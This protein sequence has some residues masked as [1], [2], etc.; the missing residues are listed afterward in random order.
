MSDWEAEG[1]LKG[2][3]GRARAA[4]RELLDELDAAGVPV[5][6]LRRAV[7]EDRLALLPVERILEGEGSR[8]T[9]EEVA[10]RAGVDIELMVRQRQALGLPVGEPGE[11]AYT[12]EDLAA[13]RRVRVLL[14]AG[15]SEDGL[16]EMARVLGL[17]VSQL[18][19]ANR[20]MVGEAMLE[21]GGTELD[22]AH[23]YV[24]AARALLPLLGPSL[25]HILRLHL[26][27]QLRHDA[28]GRAELAAGRLAGSQEVT[29]CFADLV[30]FTKL[31]ERLEAE[32]LGAV[33]GRLNELASSVV[34]SPVRLVKMIGDAAMLVAP[35]NEAVLDAALSLIDAAEDAGE[36]FP[37][38]RAGV[39]RG[40]ALA[41][42]GDWYGRPVNLASRITSIA[43]PGSVLCSKGVH[44]L[45]GDGYAWSFAGSRRLK[46]IRDEVALFRCRRG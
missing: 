6:E 46:G 16:Y 21:P 14:D 37:L 12:E 15:V 11:E 35:H 3:R 44:D 39:A 1:L 30:G 34:R 5:E 8:Y 43:Y 9:A 28:I 38:L 26:R 10:E 23:R 17:A 7:A 20:A 40:P 4:R 27:E 24:D 2:L 36:D 42:G 25:E 31:G 41:R 32:E 19:A 45:A 18:A 33:T 13:A 29:A 22:A